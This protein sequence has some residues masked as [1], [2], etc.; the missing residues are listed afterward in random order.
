METVRDA[1]EAF[2]RK[3]IPALT[4][5]TTADTEWETLTGVA[6]ET[7]VY[8][9]HAGLRRYFRDAGAIWSE[10]A[11]KITGLRDLGGRGVLILATLCA[12][13]SASG[14]EVEAPFASLVEFRGPKIR[15]IQTF[16]DEKAAL[17][18]SGLRQ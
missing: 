3:D 9:G 16:P 15:R 13:G 6:V 2:N 4:A 14:V 5:I 18:A 11:I 1:V 10:I 17:E 7:T 12:T 8:R